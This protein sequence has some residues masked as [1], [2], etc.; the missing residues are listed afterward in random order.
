MEM[1]TM[2]KNSLICNFIDEHPKDWSVLMSEMGITVK[3]DTRS[4]KNR[5]AIFNYDVMADFHNPIVQEARGIIINLDTLTVVC[6]P[7]RKFGNYGESYADQIDWSTARVQDKVDGSIVKLWYMDNEWFWST[8]GTINAKEASTIEDTSSILYDNYLELIKKADNYAQI[9]FS[10]L[11]KDRTYIFELISPENQV[12]IR[13]DKTHLIHTGTRDNNTGEEY[14][15][16]I[17]IEEPLEYD[18]HSL[19]DCLNAAEKLNA[20]GFVKKE[21]FVVVD[22]NF[23][24][25]KIKS[26]EY[27]YMHRIVDNGNVSARRMLELLRSVNTS[28]LDNFIKDRPLFE[29]HIS[30]YRFKLS[31]LE[32]MIDRFIGFALNLYAEYSFER[33]AVAAKIEKNPLAPFAFK[34]I[35]GQVLSGK[36]W[37]KKMSISQLERL[38]P[39]YHMP[40]VI[41]LCNTK[42]VEVERE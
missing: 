18:L 9:P 4:F 16:D 5:I 13:Y 31:E 39:E 23:H 34:A 29:V 38:V 27:L 30:Y 22:E 37:V 10:D 19:D 11:H 14:C 8:N 35:D 36:E 25:I 41:A 24:R 1:I 7:F 12:V 42:S 32:Q 40:D 28:E 26:P 6:W 3:T 2:N 20:S 33:K 15:E 21:G 17:G